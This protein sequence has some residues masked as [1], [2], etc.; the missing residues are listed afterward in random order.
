MPETNN[1]PD[2]YSPDEKIDTGRD[3]SSR[4]LELLLEQ[5]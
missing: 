4:V 1:S 5:V 3:S 2:R